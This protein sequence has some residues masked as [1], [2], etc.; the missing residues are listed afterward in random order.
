[1]DKF[2]YLIRHDI[3]PDLITA[4]SIIKYSINTIISQYNNFVEKQ[5][6]GVFNK[7]M[8]Y[9]NINIDSSISQDNKLILK[10]DVGFS[11]ESEKACDNFIKEIADLKK[12]TEEL[13]VKGVL[14]EK[15]K[16]RINETWKFLEQMLST[17]ELSPDVSEEEIYQQLKKEYAV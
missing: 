3:T 2:S 4:M 15:Q 6:L 14:L 7:K 9:P 13:Q 16:A 17:P 10:F 8:L 1:M 12:Q 5:S 11:E